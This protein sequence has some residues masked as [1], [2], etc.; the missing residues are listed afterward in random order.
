[1][2]LSEDS[3]VDLGDREEYR[4]DTNSFNWAKTPRK[5]KT[6]TKLNIKKRESKL[7]PIF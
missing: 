4:V 5:K 1:M 2:I 6:K 3:F 7:I